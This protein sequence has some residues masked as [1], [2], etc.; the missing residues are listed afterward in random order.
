VP[1][2]EIVRQAMASMGMDMDLVSNLSQTFDGRMSTLK[3]TFTNLAGAFT[4][5]IFSFISDQIFGLQGTLDENMPAIEERL[6]GAGQFI[7]DTFAT[8][9]QAWNG[10][11][12]DSDVI[13]PMHRLAGLLAIE[14]R[15]GWDTFNR[16][17]KDAQALWASG[18]IQEKIL[19]PLGELATLIR[20]NFVKDWQKL[21]EE[22]RNLNKVGEAWNELMDS[23]RQLWATVVGLAA[24]LGIN[25]GGA[26]DSFSRLNPEMRKS[27]SLGEMLI[28]IF[29]AL[30]T[31][32]TYASIGINLVVVGL[33][34]FINWVNQALAT[35]RNL[36]AAVAGG[37][38]YPQ[39]VP[40]GGTDVG[41]T[42]STTTGGTTVGGGVPVGER[43]AMSGGVVIYATVRNDQDIH[44]LA[45]EIS[46]VQKANR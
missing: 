27:A 8:L 23:G 10:E 43:G 29:D 40:V 39:G 3:D 19:A 6:R 33:Q 5:P 9:Q 20:E 4:Q 38:A 18:W 16:L 32:A 13:Q 12:V 22:W 26:S 1:N 7:A 14:L 30:R 28:D 34:S 37:V 36:Q 44:A 24:T 11:W 35:W 17:V 31:F 15:E 2:I 21:V 46:K 41:G 45:Y 42:G 25:I